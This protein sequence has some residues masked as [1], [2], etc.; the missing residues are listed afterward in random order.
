LEY[1]PKK[2]AGPSCSEAT[3][4]SSAGIVPTIRKAL[5]PLAN[6]DVIVGKLNLGTDRK[7]L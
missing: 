7:K 5:A 1:R 3:E 4:N 2:L 6:M